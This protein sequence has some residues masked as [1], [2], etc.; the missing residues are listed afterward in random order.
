MAGSRRHFG[1]SDDN[2]RVYVV[3]LDEST[4]E[5]LFLSFEQ[6]IDNNVYSDLG[7][8]IKASSKTP[9]AMRY[10]LCQ[11]L[12]GDGRVVKRKVFVGSINSLVWGTGINSITLDGENYGITAKIGEQRA[13]LPGTDTGLVDGDVE[14]EITTTPAP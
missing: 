1:Y 7:R 2:G 6:T 12:D 9:I 5:N 10:I 8:R 13:I 14:N 3:N 4:Y 11:R